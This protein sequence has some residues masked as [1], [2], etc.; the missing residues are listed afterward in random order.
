MVSGTAQMWAKCALFYSLFFSLEESLISGD[1]LDGSVAV[2]ALDQNMRYVHPLLNFLG[3]RA[4]PVLCVLISLVSQSFPSQTQGTRVRS[5]LVRRLLLRT[6]LCNEWG[7]MNVVEPTLSRFSAP[8]NLADTS[9]EDRVCIS[10][11]LHWAAWL[12]HL[13]F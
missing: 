4:V 9:D 2:L 6:T 13:L 11:S 12:G 8:H 7:S 1:S 3:S 5:C 10:Y